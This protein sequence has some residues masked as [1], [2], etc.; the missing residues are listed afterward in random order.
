MY[1]RQI[2]NNKGD[3]PKYRDT[4]IYIT[5]SD[6]AIETYHSSLINLINQLDEKDW[7]YDC[8][9]TI[10]HIGVYKND[11]RMYGQF[12]MKSLCDPFPF[13]DLMASRGIVICEP[14]FL[15][16]IGDDKIIDIVLGRIKIYIGIDFEKFIEISNLLGIKASWS[17]SKES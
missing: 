3:D 9:E 15:K 14:I 6:I 4:K 2:Q 5:E 11:W 17:S 12:S 10:V 16:P 7:A 1:K 8:I 13:V